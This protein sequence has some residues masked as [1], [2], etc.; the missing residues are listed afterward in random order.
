MCS[1]MARII[2]AQIIIASNAIS[3]K[4]R[5]IAYKTRLIAGEAAVIKC[6]SFLAAENLLE[7]NSIALRH[8]IIYNGIYGANQN[9]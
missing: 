3:T 9:G 2:A 5:F 8:H 7:G 4:T 6:S 1:I